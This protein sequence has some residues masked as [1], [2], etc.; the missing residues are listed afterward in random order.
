MFKWIFYWLFLIFYVVDLNNEHLSNRFEH[1]VSCS[2]L[3]QWKAQSVQGPGQCHVGRPE[4]STGSNHL[5]TQPHTYERW[6]MSTINVHRSTLPGDFSSTRWCS[7]MTKTWEPFS[8]YLV[9]KTLEDQSSWMFYRWDFLKIFWRIW[10][11]Q[12]KIRLY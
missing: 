12:M 10:F 7:R 6:T 8:R 2:L 3:Q 1:K 5:P 4:G 11:G 9:G